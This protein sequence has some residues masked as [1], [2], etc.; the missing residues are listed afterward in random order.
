[1]F[2]LSR[3]RD[4]RCALVTGVQTCALPSLGIELPDANAV[5]PRLQQSREASRHQT[6]AKGGDH[7]AGDKNEPRHGR[8]DLP[9]RRGTAQAVESQTAEINPPRGCEDRKRVV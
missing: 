5:T 7:A 8:K 4:T 1:M 3:R 9:G 6:F 2:F